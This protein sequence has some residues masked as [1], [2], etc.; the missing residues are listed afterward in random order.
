MLWRL[1]PKLSYKASSK[2]CRHITKK[3]A[4]CTKLLKQFILVT[5]ICLIYLHMAE[6]SYLNN[7]SVEYIFVFFAQRNYFNR[8]FGRFCLY[9]ILFGTDRSFIFLRVVSRA[10]YFRKTGGHPKSEAP[11]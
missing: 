8:F 5:L 6:I 10:N 1:L 7:R 11:K 2:C 9:D 4:G 3:D